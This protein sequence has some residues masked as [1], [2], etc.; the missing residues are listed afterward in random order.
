MK[1]ILIAPILILLLTGLA[2]A[3][4]VTEVNMALKGTSAGVN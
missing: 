3:N 1:Q 2:G 4:H